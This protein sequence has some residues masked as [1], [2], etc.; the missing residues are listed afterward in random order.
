MK[1]I[2]EIRDWRIREETADSRNRLFYHGSIL[3]KKKRK[4]EREGDLALYIPK[5]PYQPNAT[6]HKPVVCIILKLN[7]SMAKD[8]HKV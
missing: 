4:I 6:R 3:N 8:L 1:G 7:R 5:V 2:T